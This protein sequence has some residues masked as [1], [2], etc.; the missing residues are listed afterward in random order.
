MRYIVYTPMIFIIQ[1]DFTYMKLTN[2][3]KELCRL[4]YGAIEIGAIKIY[5]GN[6]HANCKLPFP[7]YTYKFLHQFS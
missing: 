5:T 6:I 4:V 2:K 7:F 3:C 1:V